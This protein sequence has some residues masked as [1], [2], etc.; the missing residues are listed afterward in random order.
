[1]FG[2]FGFIYPQVKKKDGNQEDLEPLDLIT[3]FGETFLKADTY[4]AQ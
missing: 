3:H 2:R 4:P 1:M